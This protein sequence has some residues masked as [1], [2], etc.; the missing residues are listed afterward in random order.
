MDHSTI[1]ALDVAIPKDCAGAARAALEQALRSA[2][3]VDLSWIDSLP[4]AD[5]WTLTPE[6][7]RFLW[8]LVRV[9][10]PR[11]ILEFGSGLSTQVLGRACAGLRPTCCITSVDHDPDFGR[12]AAQAF[13]RHSESPLVLRD[14]GGKLLPSYY[15]QPKRF[16]SRRPPDLIVIDGPPTTLGGREGALY[17]ALDLARPGTLVLLDDADREGERTALACWQASVGAAVE[18]NLL[19]GFLKGLAA[20]IVREPVATAELWVQRVRSAVQELQLHI[21]AGAAWILVDGDVFGTCADLPGRRRLPFVEWDGQYWGP[22]ED[23]AAAIRELD[24]LR[25]AGADFLVLAWPAFWWLDHY[26]GWRRHLRSQFHCV[27]ENDRF[28]LLDLRLG[29]GDSLSGDA[30]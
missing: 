29:V 25:N 13:A 7:L 10:K 18:V 12:K 23:D 16:A 14:H 15:L 1:P 11:H 27:V 30:V 4:V 24:R 22:P 26:A 19:S 5:G 6:V 3:S 28:I 20:A 2:D 17:Q 9:F 8:K 21:P